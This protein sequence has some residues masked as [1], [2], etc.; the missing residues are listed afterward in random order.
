MGS[1]DRRGVVRS[2]LVVL[3]LLPE[4][5]AGA[6]V[7]RRRL[8]ALASAGVASLPLRTR[9]TPA[10]APSAAPARARVTQR[11]FVDVRII[12]SYTMSE[13]LENA[14]LRGRLTLGLYGDDAPKQTTRFVQLLTG[15]RAGR[16]AEADSFPSLASASFERRRPPELL[17]SGPVPGVRELRLPES[18]GGGQQYEWNA[19]IVPLAPVF[20]SVRLRHDRRGL[21]THRIADG[22][23][24]FGITL[25]PAPQLDRDWAVFG[26]VLEGA[27]PL[28]LLAE[29][30]ALPFLTGEAAPDSATGRVGA[31]VYAAQRSAFMAL[32]Q[33]IGDTRADERVGRLLRR[34]EIVSTGLLPS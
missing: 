25:A 31:A 1:F 2:A 9:A 4:R 22:G 12:E 8:A 5:G 21:L 14:A 19:Q 28:G 17:L 29:I 13:V 3:A 18:L 16:P 20:E 34:V 24:V 10:P 33:A 7:T 27:E 23:T 30:E 26:E 6:A 32:T 15:R 11:A